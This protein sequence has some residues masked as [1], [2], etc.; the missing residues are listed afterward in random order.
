MCL[1]VEQLSMRHSQST[2]HTLDLLSHVILRRSVRS[3]YCNTV[4][5]TVLCRRRYVLG[6]SGRLR[7]IQFV[8]NDMY[9]YNFSAVA[10]EDELI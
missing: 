1:C 2:W 9:M 4:C 10:D 3:P 7:V 5:Q 6:L 8:S